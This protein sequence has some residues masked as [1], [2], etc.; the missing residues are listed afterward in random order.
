MLPSIVKLPPLPQDVWRAVIFALAAA[1]PLSDQFS[2]SGAVV[3]AQGGAGSAMKRAVRFRRGIDFAVAC[4]L[5][6]AAISRLV[7]ALDEIGALAKLLPLRPGRP[8]KG[9]SGR[10]QRRAARCRK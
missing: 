5:T 4:V 3:S 8:F 7:C 6:T 2:V 9:A 1:S 10:S